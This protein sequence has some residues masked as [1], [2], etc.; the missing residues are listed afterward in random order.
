MEAVR[1]GNHRLLFSSLSFVGYILNLLQDRAFRF[2]PI[3]PLPFLVMKV[4]FLLLSTPL[5]ISANGSA[6]RGATL[7]LLAALRGLNIVATPPLV[8]SPFAPINSYETL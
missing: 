3:L 5:S 6:F 2:T 8:S 4:S 7:S 1:L